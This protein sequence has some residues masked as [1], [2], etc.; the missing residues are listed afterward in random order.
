MPDKDRKARA[1]SPFLQALRERPLLADGAMGTLLYS[2]GASFEACFEHLNNTRQDTVQQVHVDYLNAG[3]D[4]VETNSFA[5]NRFKLAQHSME[6][7][8]WKLNV[9]AAKIARNAREITG[10]PA[11]IAGSVGPTGRLLPPLGDLDRDSLNDAYC[12]QM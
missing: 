6:N 3:C 12:E 8:V 5:G 4:I 2:R 11:F 1:Q 10:S 7:E 9:W